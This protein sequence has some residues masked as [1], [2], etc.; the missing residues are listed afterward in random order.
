MI[1]KLHNKL[2]IYGDFMYDF[3]KIYQSLIGYDKILLNKSIDY[4]YEKKFIIYFKNYFIDKYS[5]ENFNNLKLITKGLIFSLIPLHN[6]SNYISE[7]YQLLNSEY[8]N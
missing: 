3:A 2:T 5:S 7:L 1:G 4:E 6:N 8:I